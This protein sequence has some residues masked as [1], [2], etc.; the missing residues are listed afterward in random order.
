MNHHIKY[1]QLRAFCL[2]AKGSSFKAAAQAMSI[3]QSSLSSLVKELE[4]DLGLELLVRTT[5]SCKLTEAGAAFLAEI[6]GPMDSLEGAYSHARKVGAGN[7]GKLDL[8]ALSSL[9]SGVLV[10][11]LA[12]YQRMHPGVRIR[13]SESSHIGVIDA[14]RN[15]SAELG[16][17]SRPKDADG[18][19][20]EPL[21]AD[22]LMLIS[23]KGHASVKLPADWQTVGQFPFI[24]MMSGFAQRALMAAGVEA[25][26]AFEVQQSSTAL[27]MVRHGMGVTV[28]PSSILPNFNTAG[29]VCRPIDDE[30]AIRPLGAIRLAATKPSQ[31]ARLFF[32]M[33]VAAS[34][35]HHWQE[36]SLPPVRS[37]RASGRSGGRDHRER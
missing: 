1:R 16:I 34:G 5:R 15:G 24:L 7:L 8:A 22:R 9:C 12:Q 27:A 37:R 18:L 31:P 4:S 32:D 13:L 23:P 30:L 28:L 36:L 33:L 3:T 2:V 20:F 35:A 21:F 19:V 14:V 29:L 25:R 11:E 10:R 6:S 26:P 17:G